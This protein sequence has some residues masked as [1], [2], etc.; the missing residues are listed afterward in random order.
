VIIINLLYR[1]LQGYLHSQLRGLRPSADQRLQTQC[2]PHVATYYMALFIIIIYLC[3]QYIHSS[4]ILLY[5][6]TTRI[7][8]SYVL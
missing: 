3:T 2:V 8:D 5:F 7:G 4:F 6:Y 1:I